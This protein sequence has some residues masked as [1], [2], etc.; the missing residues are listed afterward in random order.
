MATII[1]ITAQTEK[2]LIRKPLSGAKKK[3]KQQPAV[4][5]TAITT[6]TRNGKKKKQPPP[7][8]FD[9]QVLRR[10]IDALPSKRLR[11]KADAFVGRMRKL[12]MLFLDADG[13]IRFDEASVEVPEDVETSYLHTL[14]HWFL[15]SR[16]ASQR[17]KLSQPLDADMFERTVIHADSELAKMVARDKLHNGRRLTTAKKKRSIVETTDN[18]QIS[19]NNSSSNSNNNVG[20]KWIKLNYS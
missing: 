17:A 11:T 16:K 10:E 3:S 6:A 14:L 12:N 7:S 19:G 5:A 8:S 20:S 18:R 4:M 9:D 13:R 1:P 2:V 15:T